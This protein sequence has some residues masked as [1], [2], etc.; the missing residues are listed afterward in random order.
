MR[1]RRRILFGL[2]LLVVVVI[3][4]LGRG[5]KKHLEPLAEVELGFDPEAMAF[6]QNH[7][8]TWDGD[9]LRAF[10]DQGKEVHRADFAMQGLRCTLRKDGAYLYDQDLKKLLVYDGN[11]KEVDQYPLEGE[12]YDIKGEN[13]ILHIKG[14]G[15][16]QLASLDASRGVQ[17]F[18]QTENFIL[19]WELDSKGNGVV[20]ELSTSAGGYKTTLYLL[21]GDGRKIDFP[22]EVAMGIWSHKH[23]ALVLTEKTLKSVGEEVEEM[24]VPLP[25]AAVKTK[26]GVALFH[27][28][29]LT[30]YDE[31][32]REK[33]SEILPAHVERLLREDDRLM[34][35]GP[36]DVLWDLG[37]RHESLLR[38]G[39]RMDFVDLS[40][41]RLAAIRDRTLSIWSLADGEETEGA[42]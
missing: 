36:G 14:E 13:P 11:C 15:F 8:L 12:L 28:G 37:G 4:F 24:T 27:S 2:L 30:F 6:V 33:K 9:I 19:S 10:D 20:S 29:V 38:L 39:S 22:S 21:G 40:K 41:D 16:E 32:L 5:S 26:E 34:A 31:K 7:L 1:R 25:Q 18:F 17:S 3:F 23:H 42:S 35:L